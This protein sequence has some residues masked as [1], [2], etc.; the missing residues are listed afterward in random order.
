MTLLGGAQGDE[1][2]QVVE[3]V[4]SKMEVYCRKASGSTTIRCHNN[5]CRFVCGKTDI[6]GND[7]GIV[8]ATIEICTTATAS[9]FPICYRGFGPRRVQ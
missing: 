5:H 6:P 9:S 7:S 3:L 2:R 8:V 1:Y 4:V